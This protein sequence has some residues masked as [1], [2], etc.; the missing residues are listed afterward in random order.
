MKR[1]TELL[2][3]YLETEDREKLKENSYQVFSNRM[4]S[5]RD[6]SLSIEEFVQLSE[7][8]NDLYR[9]EHEFIQFLATN[10]TIEDLKNEFKFN[11]TEIGDLYRKHSKELY[12]QE[13]QK[14]KAKSS[15]KKP[16][17]DIKNKT[18]KCS[19]GGNCGTK[20]EKKPTN[21]TSQ[22]KT[23]DELLKELSEN[24]KKV[25]NDSKVSSNEGFD[26]VFED[27]FKTLNDPKLHE[28]KQEFEDFVNHVIIKLFRDK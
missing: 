25:N 6:S 8:Y 4:K 12:D 23:L 21:K 2:E 20:T 7:L 9:A 26:R 27:I 28:N 16:A 17:E 10:K 18:H 11:E 13:V 19:C 1:M 15:T 5:I 24:G 22:T 14:N 3:I